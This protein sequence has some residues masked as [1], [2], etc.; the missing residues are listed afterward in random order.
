MNIV[1]D[2]GNS[3]M[4][5]AV[6]QDGS[7]KDYNTYPT[8]DLMRTPERVSES[9]LFKNNQFDY[10]LM[11]SVVPEANGIMKCVL[12]NAVKKR[13]FSVP[14]MNLDMDIAYEGLLGEDRIAGAYAAM[15]LYGAPV[16]V[17]DVGTALTFSLVDE[18]KTFKGGMISLGPYSLLKTLS[19]KTSQLSMFDLEIPGRNVGKN[20]EE[21][22]NSGVFWTVLGAID[23]CVKRIEEF[24]GGSCSLVL[25]GGYSVFFAEFVK[26]E[27]EIDPLL[28]LK[29]LNIMLNDNLKTN[30]GGTDG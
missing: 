3:M 4:K 1:V 21:A 26:H 16:I 22:I 30:S 20:S 18:K 17:V 29:G 25:T 6:F 24:Q 10:A 11:S 27:A 8:R 15:N 7:L 12:T 2:I 13:L 19:E 9:D 23:N 14:D 28:V 5:A